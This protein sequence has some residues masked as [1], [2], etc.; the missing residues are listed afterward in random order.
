MGTLYPHGQWFYFPIAFVIKSTIGF[1]LVL[2]L[3][4]IFAKWKDAET[5]RKLAYLFVPIVVVLIAGMASGLNIGYR[6]VMPIIGFLCVF[7]GAAAAQLWSKGTAFRAAV[8]LLFL[9]HVLSSALTFPNYIPYSNEMFGRSPNTYRYLTDANVDWG[10]ALIQTRDW[11]KDNHIQDCWIAY[12]GAIDPDFYALP[13]RRLAGNQW[14]PQVVP[15]QPVEGVFLL[16]PLTVSGIEWEPGDLHPYKKFMNEKPVANIGNAMLVFR[17]T[18]DLTKAAAVANIAR[19]NSDA[20]DSPEVGLEDG[21]RAVAL[22]PNSVR[23][24]L[25]LGQAFERAKQFDAARVE[26]QAALAQA[27]KTGDAWYP[28]EI[29]AADRGLRQVGTMKSQ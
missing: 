8:A 24:H 12:D 27:H 1:M 2:G 3:G 7:A 29:A 26:Y 16:S 17:G 10:Q 4:L 23:A 25:A 5:R 13:C 15:S 22:T 11:L 19:T 18:Y 9:A 20:D 21:R 28:N 6:H 14:D